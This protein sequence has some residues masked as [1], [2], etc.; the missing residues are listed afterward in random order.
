MTHLIKRAA[1]YTIDCLLCYSVI[2]LI[3]QWAILSNI[4]E[5]VG[6][7]D[8]WFEDSWHAQLYVLTTISLPV[9][10]YFTYFDSHKTR[11]TF[12]KRL[13][14]LNLVDQSG[15]RISQAK[16]LIRTFLKLS[17]WEIAHVGVIFPVPLYFTDEPEIRLLT[18][19]GISL[20]TIWVLSILAN[21]KRQSLYDKLLGTQVLEQKD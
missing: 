4:R 9:W 21:T 11:G 14:K 10:W 20:F 13:L 8:A 2:M 15:G 17:P 1:A 12:G 19:L 5:S 3:V 18:L 7:T 16:S 6:I